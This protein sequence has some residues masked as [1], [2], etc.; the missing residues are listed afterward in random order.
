MDGWM[1]GQKDG[2]I[3]NA[4]TINSSTLACLAEIKSG[5]TLFIKEGT[6][7]AMCILLWLTMVPQYRSNCLDSK[8][9]GQ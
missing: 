2:W 9:K 4:K 7:K 1:D 6:E 5:P 8:L 3:D